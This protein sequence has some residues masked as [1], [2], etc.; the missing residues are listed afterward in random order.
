[1]IP[2]LVNERFQLQRL[3]G[4][5]GNGKSIMKREQVRMWSVAGIILAVG[6]TERGTK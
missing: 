2:I 3:Y 5:E 6:W 1:M 4:I